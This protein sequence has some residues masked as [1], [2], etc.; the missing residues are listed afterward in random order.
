M[1]NRIRCYILLIIFMISI[2]SVFASEVDTVKWLWEGLHMF[3]LE[4]TSQKTSSINDE[5]GYSDIDWGSF[6]IQFPIHR[7]K[8]SPF[9]FGAG[10]IYNQYH[11]DYNGP[12]LDS[13]NIDFK[14]KTAHG[15]KLLL[16]FNYRFGG[17]NHI[18][19]EYNGGIDGWFKNVGTD[20]INHLLFAY[21][22]RKPT[23]NVY[24]RLGIAGSYSFENLLI[25][26]LAGFS[27]GF[28]DHLAFELMFPK[29]VMLRTRINERFESGLRL[30]IP[31]KDV[32]CSTSSNDIKISFQQLNGGLYFDTRIIKTLTARVEGGVSFWREWVINKRGISKEMELS[33]GVTPYLRFTLRWQV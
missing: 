10:L 16:G 29:H 9:Y 18:Y 15:I 2:E 17:K 8:E 20:H 14:S 33:P 30:G 27:I 5:N 19:W 12:N 1:I 32:G 23:K 24:F 28:N 31:I 21:V 4:V 13:M 25:L 11:L 7:K 6:Y 26:P 22:G 3:N